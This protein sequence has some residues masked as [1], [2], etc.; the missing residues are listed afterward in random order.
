MNY[1]IGLLSYA[2]APVFANNF[3]EK[4]DNSHILKSAGNLKEMYFFNV[5]SFY[6]NSS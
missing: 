1:F 6:L 5:S 3:K 4:G 2:N